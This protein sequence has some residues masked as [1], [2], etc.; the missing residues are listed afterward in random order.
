MKKFMHNDYGYLRRQG[1]EV[2]TEHRSGVFA[3]CSCAS[4]GSPMTLPPD[5]KACMLLFMATSLLAPAPGHHQVRERRE[6]ER[7][8]VA[9][10]YTKARYQGKM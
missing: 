2:A 3:P 10:T 1:G 9:N 4:A 5:P 6:R 7:P 8:K